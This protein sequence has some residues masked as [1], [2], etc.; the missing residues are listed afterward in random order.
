MIEAPTVSERICKSKDF[1]PFSPEATRQ[2]LGTS[3]GP[4]Q[5]QL[6]LSITEPSLQPQTGYILIITVKGFL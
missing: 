6:G 3:L 4:L 1:C 2:L 5:Q